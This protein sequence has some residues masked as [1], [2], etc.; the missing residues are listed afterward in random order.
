M[1]LFKWFNTVKH[2][3]QPEVRMYGK[4]TAPHC[5]SDRSSAQ[6]V[7]FTSTRLTYMLNTLSSS[8]Y[9]NAITYTENS[10][11]RSTRS[12]SKYSRR[13]VTVTLPA[14]SSSPPPN[15]HSRLY[16]SVDEHLIKSLCAHT[17]SRWVV[18]SKCNVLV[19]H[20]QKSTTACKLNSNNF[21]SNYLLLSVF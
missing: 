12:W 17:V 5:D 4:A 11:H 1:L 6:Y 18:I 10:S 13:G 9:R 2:R 3:R 7:V 21:L 19:Q 8:G 16:H 15:H 14:A 20:I